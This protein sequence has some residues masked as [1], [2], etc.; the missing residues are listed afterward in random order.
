MLPGLLFSVSDKTSLQN[1]E[2]HFGESE[3][4]GF[5]ADIRIQNDPYLL[6]FDLI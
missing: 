2:Y 1:V 4:V 6:T 5:E 3:D